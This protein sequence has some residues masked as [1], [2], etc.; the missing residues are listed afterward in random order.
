MASF[1]LQL[2]HCLLV[3]P[4]T[5]AAA[6]G[7][8][9][10]CALEWNCC[11]ILAD[12]TAHHICHMPHTHRSHFTFYVMNREATPV[13][14]FHP[15]PGVRGWNHSPPGP[16]GVNDYQKQKPYANMLSS[17]THILAIYAESYEK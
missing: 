8:L 15:P 14:N 4:Q 10:C 17:S 1:R 5:A 12:V 3:Q 13:F 9:L 2:L 11:S 16:R 6:G 7:G